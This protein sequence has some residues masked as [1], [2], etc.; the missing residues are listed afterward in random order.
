[1]TSEEQENHFRCG[2][3]S[4]HFIKDHKNMSSLIFNL[5]ANLYAFVLSVC[6]VLFQIYSPDHTNNSFSSNPS[7][8][9]GSPPSLTGNASF[10]RITNPSQK[11]AHCIVG[12]WHII[13]IVSKRTRSHGDALSE[14]VYANTYLRVQQKC[15]NAPVS[16]W[17][18]WRS[19]YCSCAKA[20]Q[21]F[22]SRLSHHY[23]V[24]METTAT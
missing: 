17:K 8:P 20:L 12:Y 14:D 23:R 3:C 16:S 18:A 6:L 19:S 10:S 5:E 11:W 22:I 4:C 2:E 13:L 1:M 21:A 9:V 15:F 7:T 24:V